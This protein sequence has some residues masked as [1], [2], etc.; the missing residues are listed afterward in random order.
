MFSSL[1]FIDFYTNSGSVFSFG[2]K[3]KW[4]NNNNK[5][6]VPT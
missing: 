4:N 3:Y 2:S 6:N 5:K 1:H